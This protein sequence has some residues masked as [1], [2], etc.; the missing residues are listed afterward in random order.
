[1]RG[2]GRPMTFSIAGRTAIVTGASSGLGVRFAQVLAEAGANVVVVARREE[3][4]AQ[5]AK[6]I[7]ANGGIVPVYPSMAAIASPRIS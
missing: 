2:E 5:V 7:E 3:Q 1:M 6:E 4:L